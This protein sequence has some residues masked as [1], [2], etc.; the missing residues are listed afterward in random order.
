MS[1]KP[2][3]G[4]PT[5]KRGRGSNQVPGEPAASDQCHLLWNQSSG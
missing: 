5:R 3:H 1:Y 4:N 2:A